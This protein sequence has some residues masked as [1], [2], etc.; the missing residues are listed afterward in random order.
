MRAKFVNEN[1]KHLTGRNEDEIIPSEIIDTDNRNIYST[2]HQVYL[3]Y[4]NA[5]EI[6]YD[7]DPEYFAVWFTHNKDTFGIGKNP[8]NELPYEVI[9]ESGKYPTDDHQ[10][11]ETLEEAK[12]L[13]ISWIESNSENDEDEYEEDED[14]YEEDEDEYEEDEDE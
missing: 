2:V 10:E 14:E 7:N 9:W 4:N 5:K 13:L 6:D 1:I 12:E 3:N 11:V 8:D